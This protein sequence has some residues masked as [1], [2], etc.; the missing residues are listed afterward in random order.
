MRGAE[1]VPGRENSGSLYRRR[2]V[3][4]EDENGDK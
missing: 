3:S 4:E 2:R 1:R